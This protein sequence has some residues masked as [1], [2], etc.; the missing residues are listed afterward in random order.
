MAA[1]TLDVTFDSNY[2]GNHV[3]CWRFNGSG[4]YDCSTVVSCTGGGASCTVSIPFTYTGACNAL[5]DGYVQPECDPGASY[6]VPFVIA[7]DPCV[8]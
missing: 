4:P 3:V 6:I 7:F 2:N 8:V 5:I 1:G